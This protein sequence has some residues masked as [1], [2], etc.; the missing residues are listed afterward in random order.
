M[1]GDDI[2]QAHNV[3]LQHCRSPMAGRRR[4]LT[5]RASRLRRMARRS[6]TYR[7]I[8]NRQ[9]IHIRHFSCALLRESFGIR[10]NCSPLPFG[11]C[12]LHRDSVWPRPSLLP[13]WLRD[14]PQNRAIWRQDFGVAGRT[15]AGENKSSRG[16]WYLY[17]RSEISTTAR[18]ANIVR[19]RSPCLTTVQTPAAAARSSP[20]RTTCVLLAVPSKATKC[21]PNTARSRD[22]FP[23]QVSQASWNGPGLGRF[24][25]IWKKESG[26]AAWTYLF[27][28]L[29][30]SASL[31]V[32]VT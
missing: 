26:T 29:S 25:A 12:R 4:R 15:Y 9:Q 22:Y 31:S 10:H 6:P 32:L 27:R 1:G 24:S 21:C 8:Q 3:S 23:I 11:R 14:I 28:T 20:S 5:A 2:L 18:G 19:Y 17:Y 16:P 7:G 13:P 30:T